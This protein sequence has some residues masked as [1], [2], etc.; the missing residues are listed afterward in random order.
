MMI[1]RP[2]VESD[3]EDFIALASKTGYGVT[4]LPSDRSLL[5]SRLN[6]ALVSFNQSVNKQDGHYLF[7][8][9]DVA[10]RKVV[11]C[12]G[13]EAAVGR[14]DVW[15]NYRISTTVNACKELNLHQETATLYLTNDMTGKSEVCSLFLDPDYRKNSNGQLLSKCRFMFL[16]AFPDYFSD[17][18]FAEMRGVSDEQGH[19]PFW[20]GLGQKFFTMEFTRADYLSGIGSK[21]FIAELMP[22]YPIYLPMLPSTAREVV[23]QVHDNTRPALAMLQAEGFNFNGFIDIFDGGPVVEAFVNNI[24]MVRECT[25]RHA[26]VMQGSEG[27][28]AGYDN[29]DKKDLWLVANTSFSEFRV[30]MI[31]GRQIRPDTVDI[32]AVLAKSLLIESGDT[33]RVARLR[34]QWR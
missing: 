34:D 32:P 22:K 28:E 9:E 6:K 27:Q 17:K 12:C 16:A 1:I 25:K 20:D 30:A 19:A 31:S 5:E 10:L 26:V 29:L 21:A 14:D 18:V 24:R 11:G 4:S 2:I 13:I 23:G 7:V 8:L 33:V 15:Y 3:L